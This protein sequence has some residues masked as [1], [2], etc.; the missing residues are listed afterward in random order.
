MIASLVYKKINWDQT[1]AIPYMS[2]SVEFGVVLDLRGLLSKSNV[3]LVPRDVH[4]LRHYGKPKDIG[5]GG[6]VKQQEV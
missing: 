3:R 4:N 2:W 6:T 1:H 5:V